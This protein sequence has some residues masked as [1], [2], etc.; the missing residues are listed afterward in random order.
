MIPFT[1]QFPSVVIVVPS[2]TLARFIVFE[3]SLGGL[4]VSSGTHL[5]RAIS[6]NI[7]LNCNEPVRLYPDAAAFWFIDDDH[8]FDQYTLLRLLAHDKPVVVPITCLKDPPFWPCIYKDDVQDGAW[9]HYEDLG[10]ELHGLAM[11]YA[12]EHEDAAYLLDR[13]KRL[14]ERGLI[15][16][17]RRKVLPYSWQEL[18]KITG[19]LQVPSCGRSGMLIRREVFQ[20]IPAPWFELG[21]TNPEYAGEDIHFCGKLREHGIPIFADTDLTFGHVGPVTSWPMREADG[22]WRIRLIW[23]NGQAITIN[24]QDA[25]PAMVP[26]KDQRGNKIAARMAALIASGM[27]DESQ[28]FEQA[29]AD[30]DAE[31]K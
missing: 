13:L 5:S 31:G 6:A 22:S 8:Q 10:K 11:E 27:R 2:S 30:V 18:D 19:L 4:L 15:R 16:K 3:L 9:V 21:Q 20:K 12:Q 1:D 24:R 17:P 7:A 28:A 14:I 25:P 23:A 26:I 29:M